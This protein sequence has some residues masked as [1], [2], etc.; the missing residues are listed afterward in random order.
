MVATAKDIDGIDMAQL[1]CGDKGLGIKI[2]SN[3]Q[4]LSAGVEIQVDLAKSLAIFHI[5][6]YRRRKS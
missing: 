5:L 4:A 3:I 1:K 6:V 2:L